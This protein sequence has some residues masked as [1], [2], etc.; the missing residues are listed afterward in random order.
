MSTITATREVHGF[1][2]VVLRGYGDLDVEQR[3]DALGR[4]TIEIEADEELVRRILTEVRGNRLVLGFSM[5]WYEWLTW[6]FQWLF[7]PSRKIR[8]RLAAGRLEALS[9]SG[10]GTV[11]LPRL[12]SRRLD[13]RISGAGRIRGSALKVG[14]LAA[15][16]SGSGK[17]ELAGTADRCEV[18]ISG[19]GN[20][21]LTGRA[22]RC[23]IAISGSGNVRAADLEAKS[24]TAR[25]SGSGSLTT[26]AAETL[27][28]NISGAGSVR[29]RGNPRIS[30]RISGA[31]Q[32]RP[33]T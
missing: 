20:V 9:I 26:N 22:E 7:L 21:E 18:S 17:V 30:Q 14:E 28:V 19:S 25:I 3:E 29:Y 4:E 2:E 6:W 10:A 8:Y 33:L 13:L 5:P 32:I 31:G 11:T 23:E 24:V 1:T 12:D 15:R 27:D 16:V